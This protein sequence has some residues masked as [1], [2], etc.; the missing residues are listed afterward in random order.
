MRYE[1]FTLR[2]EPARDGAFAVAVESPQGEGRGS[3]H[4]PGGGA[5]TSAAAGRAGDRD[6]EVR[7]LTLPAASRKVL[8]LDAGKQLFRALFRDEVGILF[9]ASLGSLGDERLG[10]RIGLV[11]DPRHPGSARLL[12]LPW[13]LLCRPETEDF[14]CLSRRTPVVRS[15][16]AHRERRPVAA[17]PRRLRILAVAASP[18]DGPALELARE[19]RNLAAAW[20]GQE[21]SIEIVSLQRGSVEEMRQA[22]LAK[23][24]HI[25]HFM[26]H[27]SFEAGSGEGALL[28][29]RDDGTG[30]L[31]G[32]RRLAQLLH[33]FK[34]LRL[35]VLNAC[36]TAVAA[37]RDGPSP[38][39]GVASALVMGGVPAVVAMRGPV[40][41]RAAVAFSRAL[42][43]RLAAGDAI[44][45]AVTEGRL[46][47][48]RGGAEDGA[49]AIPALF[50]R[51]V[52]GMLFAPRRV[53]WVR[54]AALLAGFAVALALVW[55]LA[56]G[57]L[58]ELHGAQAMRYTNDGIGLLQLGRK[59]EARAAFR[60]ALDVDPRYAPALGNLVA[61]EM[62]L[63][64]DQAALD[65]A[66]AAA[67]AAPGE[68]VHHYNLGNLLARQ[69]HYEEALL[70][71]RRA[72][73]LDPGYAQAYNELGSVYLALARP[74]EARKAFEAGLRH[75]PA[76]AALRKN[77]GRAALAEGRA[78]EAIRHLET[79]LPLYPP[80]DPAGKAE[81]AY[82]LAVAAAQAGRGGKACAAL[83]SFAALDPRLL[84]P[85]AGEAARLARRN[86]CVPWP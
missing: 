59:E 36:H 39:S 80:A 64:E 68:A 45:A 27:G 18:S 71:L 33:D 30:E 84:T 77:L 14:L 65:H 86:R 12:E 29:E 2:I 57:W 6:G 31:C 63:G 66:Q 73:D 10:L 16:A 40:P 83:R 67:K 3:F 48:Q 69:Q 43:R 51:G 53:V 26:G 8:A 60:S 22:L 75:D 49:W 41:D 19:Q 17:R 47:I 4:V 5:L 81:A 62:A 44:E 23:P 1:S 11:I 24:F 28:F 50:L 42:Y 7:D 61:V 38:F 55:V 37:G 78:E 21:K 70:S 79:A 32:G 54:R 9:H 35:V 13:E 46:A 58:R 34:S 74:A 85:L 15:L 56:A 72:I 82:W 20:D 76:L 25:L 52:D